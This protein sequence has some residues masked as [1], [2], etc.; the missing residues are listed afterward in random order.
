MATTTMVR[1]TPETVAVYKMTG[2][3]PAAA[4]ASRLSTAEG[5]E[6]SR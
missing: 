4:P 2:E 3:G 5:T 1:P 6:D